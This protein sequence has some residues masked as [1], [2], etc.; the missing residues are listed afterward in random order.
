[1]SASMAP[2]VVHWWALGALAVVAVST[3]LI[4]WRVLVLEQDALKRRDGE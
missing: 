2:S 4:L 1:M 3:G